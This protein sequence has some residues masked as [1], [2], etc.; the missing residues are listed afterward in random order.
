LRGFLE[1]VVGGEAVG[2]DDKVAVLAGGE[3]DRDGRRQPALG[4]ASVEYLAHSADVDGV[5]LEDL[6]QRLLERV[7]AIGIEQL[8]ETRGVAAEILAAVS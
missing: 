7:G 3:R 8:Q 5:A 1:R 6:D 4:T 2:S